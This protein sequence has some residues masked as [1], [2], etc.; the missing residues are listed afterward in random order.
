VSGTILD[1]WKHSAVRRIA[2]LHGHNGRP[3]AYDLGEFATE[4]GST[5]IRRLTGPVIA[6][7]GFSWWADALGQTPDAA[8]VA[9]LERTV[10]DQ[11]GLAFDDTP[12]VF[13]GFSQGGAAALALALLG[14]RTTVAAVVCVA[15]FLPVDVPTGVGAVADPEASPRI[16]FVH[17]ADDEVVDVFLAE[18]AARLLAKAGYDTELLEI[19]GGH[20]WTTEAAHTVV[21]AL[22]A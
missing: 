22:L 2:F 18:R 21:S 15:G 16:V 12:T 13:V 4:L 19:D 8:A 5:D 7:A 11:L 17:P 20:A 6:S 9:V 10:G 1:R 3:D 14:T